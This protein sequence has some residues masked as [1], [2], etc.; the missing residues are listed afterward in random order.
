MVVQNIITGVLGMAHLVGRSNS[1]VG[2]DGFYYTSSSLQQS[3]G[4]PITHRCHSV[5]NHDDAVWDFLSHHH[6]SFVRLAIVQ[7]AIR[8]D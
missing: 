8:Y 4:T 1:N 3:T 6:H 5:N 7:I 2:D